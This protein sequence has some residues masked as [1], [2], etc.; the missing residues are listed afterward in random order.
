[1]R[2]EKERLRTLKVSFAAICSVVVV[3]VASGFAVGSL[4]ILS[5]GAHALFDALAMLILL[6]ATKASLKPPDEEHM[7]GH[8]KIEPLGGL[9]GGIILLGTGFF[10]MIESVLRLL[11]KEFFIVKELEF[12]GF[13]AI[14]YTFCIDILRVRVLHG[15]HKE[16][17]TV[18]AGFYHALAD[19]GSTFIA[20]LGFG[21]ATLGFSFSDALASLV[22]SAAIT[23][24]SM[25]LVWTSGMELSDAVSKDV[26]GKIRK[27]ITLSEGVSRVESLRV[28]RAG[29]K[30]F[31]EA[32]IQVPNYL[33]FE[34]S[35]AL[36]SKIE[37]KLKR[38]LRNAEVVIH[39]EPFE[40][41]M[42]TE[43]LVEKLAMEVEGV[44]E[45]H[46]VNAVYAHGKL[47][48]TLHA[49]VDPALSVIEAHKLAEEI[50]K[51]LKGKLGNIGNITVHIEPFD[52]RLQRGP[53]ADEEEI[54]RT[55]YK[56]AES[57]QQ[58]FR[59]ERIITYVV[60]G[61]RYINIDCCFKGQIS[62]EEAHKIA[63]KIENNVKRRFKET[64]VT[65]HMEPKK[66]E[67]TP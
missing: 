11:R 61:K 21:L 45:A 30:T 41:E 17:V 53:S 2:S 50:E 60:S 58:I 6:V 8:E 7:Y 49:D 14:A 44:K 48:I 31:V 56:T 36:A 52:G 24:L 18:Q 47:Y 25:K 43:K 3:E 5:D 23:Y 55:I 13:A 38:L 16:S 27:E 1:M 40:K 35:H 29:S 28:R 20:L 10:L 33:G 67:N 64:V 32:T 37:E 46:E 42:M 54:Q 57:F 51:K 62:I 9:A 39:V 12:A 59:V 22:L 34:E 4:A 63:S 15:A 66:E 26:A 19:L 65:V